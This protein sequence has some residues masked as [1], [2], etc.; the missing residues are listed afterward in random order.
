MSHCVHFTLLFTMPFMSPRSIYSQVLTTLRVGRHSLSSGCRP[1]FK[2]SWSAGGA[3]H[4]GKTHTHSHRQEDVDPTRP[5]HLP[6]SRT[7]PP[8]QRSPLASAMCPTVHRRS[9]RKPHASFDRTPAPQE[10]HSWHG[11]ARPMSRF[12]GPI[13]SGEGQKP[14]VS[15]VQS[16]RWRCSQTPGWGWRI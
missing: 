15:K 14:T 1:A 12:G 8:A 2:S 4:S 9:P 16:Q 5:M 7:K 6:R 3:D 10:G 11:D 13:G